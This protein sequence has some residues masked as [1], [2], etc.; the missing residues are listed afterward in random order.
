MSAQ[1]PYNYNKTSNI[2]LNFALQNAA[3]VEYD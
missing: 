1:T 3:G 2:K